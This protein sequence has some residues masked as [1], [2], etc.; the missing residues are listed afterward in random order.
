M[1][2]IPLGRTRPL[3]IERP[4]RLHSLGIV[5]FGNGVAAGAVDIDDVA[6]L[7]DSGDELLV[8]EEFD[9]LTRWRQLEPSADSLGDTFGVATDEDGN[10]VP[11]IARFRWTA[12]GAR[13]LRGIVFGR[14]EPAMPVGIA[15]TPI[16]IGSD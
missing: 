14:T 16:R 12:A 11:G 7:S 10:P 2:P 5:D 13:E 6:V 9:D 8:S 4:V 3:L 1:A 15:L